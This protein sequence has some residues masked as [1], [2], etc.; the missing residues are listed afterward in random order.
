MLLP[1]DLGNPVNRGAALNADLLYW[2][3]GM[4]NNRGSVTIFDLC[5]SVDL[6]QVAGT[7]SVD[8]VSLWNAPSKECEFN[9]PGGISVPYYAQNTSQPD[10]DYSV[11]GITVGAWLWPRNMDTYNVVLGGS[12]GSSVGG[13]FIFYVAWTGSGL[14]SNSAGGAVGASIVNMSQYRPCYATWVLDSAGYRAYADG[15]EVMNTA[16]GGARPNTPCKLYLGNDYWGY[17]ANGGIGSVR[18]WKRGLA[19]GECYAL[20]REE[21]AGNPTTLNR[22]RP[23]TSV[24]LGG[25]LPSNRRRRLLC[26]GGR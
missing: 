18:I 15:V 3:K 14:F 12:T 9:F 1:V 24:F 6:T 16:S 20:Y 2:W 5:K 25:T 23:R 11:T 4:P 22:Y 10:V 7:G 8:P 26:A 19:A 13:G 21:L 17:G